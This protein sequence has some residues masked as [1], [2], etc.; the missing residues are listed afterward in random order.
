M[1]NGTFIEEGTFEELTINTLYTIKVIYQYDLGDGNGI[2]TESVDCRLK[3]EAG[4][5]YE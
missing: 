4:D 1:K 2:V 3:V 5:Y